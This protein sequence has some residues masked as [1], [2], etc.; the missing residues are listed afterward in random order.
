MRE[1]ASTVIEAGYCCAL[2]PWF[3]KLCCSLVFWALLAWLCYW[4]ADTG[5]EFKLLT[6]FSILTNKLGTHLP[7]LN[8]WIEL[9]DGILPE[10][11]FLWIWVSSSPTAPFV[12]PTGIVPL[13]LPFLKFPSLPRGSLLRILRSNKV[14]RQIREWLLEQTMR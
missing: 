8:D 4:A 13:E 1:P 10:S 11:S 7:L 3:K 9:V 2:D 12:T 6:L 14:K 5:H